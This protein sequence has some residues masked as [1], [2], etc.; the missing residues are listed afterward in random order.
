MLS[1]FSYEIFLIL[2]IDIHL[3][4]VQ[5]IRKKHSTNFHFTVEKIKIK[6]TYLKSGFFEEL[7]VEPKEITRPHSYVDASFSDSE[8]VDELIPPG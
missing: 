7:F 5:R 2:N 3:Y 8:I 4:I 6:I 1:F